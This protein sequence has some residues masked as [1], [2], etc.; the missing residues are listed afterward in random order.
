V[1]TNNK[2]FTAKDNKGNIKE[3]EIIYKFDSSETNKSY[4]VYTDHEY[5]DGLLKVYA[6]VYDT[7]GRNKRLMPVETEEEWN[8]I[9]TFLSK[10]EGLLD[11]KN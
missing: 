10:L 5:E 7:T 1:D 3:Y 4:V 9:E 11:E 2:V 6:N 8:T